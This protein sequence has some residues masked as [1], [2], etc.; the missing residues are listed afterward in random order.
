M[1]PGNEDEAAFFARLNATVRVPY[2][3]LAVMFLGYG[4]GLGG[5]LCWMYFVEARVHPGWATA[6]EFLALFLFYC[7]VGACLLLFLFQPLRLRLAPE[8]IQIAH[9][10]RRGARLVP[11]GEIQWAVLSAYRSKVFL[12]LRCGSLRGITLAIGNYEDPGAIHDAIAAR[13]QVPIEANNWAL[14]LI[15][16]ARAHTG[17]TAPSN[18]H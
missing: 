10:F 4:L 17:A 14:R 6:A 16:R 5:T 2:L 18:D 3:N 9:W 8:G 11:W 1:T 12:E 7:L 13:L 15:G